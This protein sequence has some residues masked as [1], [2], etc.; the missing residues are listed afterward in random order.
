M[1]GELP[2]DFLRLGAQTPSDGDQQLA[3]ALDQQLNRTRP[4][5]SPAPAGSL[6]IT[7]DQVRFSL[8]SRFVLLE[9]SLSIFGLDSQAKLTKSYGLLSK[10]DPYV[11]LRVG[12]YVYETH[13]D[14]N[15]GKN[16]RWNKVVQ[17]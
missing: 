12:H 4:N 2:N 6:K 16:P 5:M 13:T 14:S 10:M 9:H 11:R 8:F 17:W 15:G 7:V 3:I 1:L